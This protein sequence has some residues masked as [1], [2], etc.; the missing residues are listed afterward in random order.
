MGDADAIVSRVM[1][2]IDIDGAIA[3]VLR[4][5]SSSGSTFTGTLTRSPQV[6]VRTS[7][8][9]IGENSQSRFSG[10]STQGGSIFSLQPRGG[11]ASSRS[12]KKTAIVGQVMTA[13][14]PP[15]EKAVADALQALSRSSS[16]SFGTSSQPA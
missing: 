11:G 9:R 1:A 15:I 10:G 16:S 3:E 13:L 7:G 6:T 2:S 14:S 4:G 12:D 5:I 8:S